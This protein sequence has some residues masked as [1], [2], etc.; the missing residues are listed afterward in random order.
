MHI[1]NRD[2]VL[3]EVSAPPAHFQVAPWRGHSTAPK[4]GSLVM[5]FAL[6]F[7]F[8]WATWIP[9][10]LASY[11]LL[12]VQVNPLLSSWLGAFGPFV[13]A[14]ITTARYEGRVG[15]RAL[16][17]RLLIWRVGIQ[18]YVFVLLWPAALSLAKTALAVLAGSAPP[19]F[20]HPPF[21]QLSPLPSGATN[22]NPLLFLPIVFVWQTLVGSSMGEEIGWRGY[23][24]PR[25]QR[26]FSSLRASLLLGACWGTWHLPLWLT[27]G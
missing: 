21:V 22:A 5:F 11:G 19:D 14:L 23:A 13:A 25:L 8:S 10:A 4:P 9:T 1:L 18:W 2:G 6:A 16:F 27:N 26:H 7:G 15:F 20:A 24:L 3:N 17:N 12:P